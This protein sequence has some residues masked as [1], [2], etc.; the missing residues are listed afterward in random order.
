[1][2][3]EGAV[4]SFMLLSQYLSGGT[5]TKSQSGYPVAGLRFEPQDLL[6]KKQECNQFTMKFGLITIII[7]CHNA[8]CVSSLEVKYQCKH[9][10]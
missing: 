7:H 5:E 10:Q 9:N 4:T 1:M 3:K 6:N 2:W 8:N